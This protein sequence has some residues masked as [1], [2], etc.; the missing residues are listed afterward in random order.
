[1]PVTTGIGLTTDPDVEW[2]ICLLENM[3]S[4]DGISRTSLGCDS[5]EVDRGD[6][7]IFGAKVWQPPPQCGTL[8]KKRHRCM[9]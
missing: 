3:L 7:P 2:L 1:M 5:V 4:T 6:L 8:C 9:Y